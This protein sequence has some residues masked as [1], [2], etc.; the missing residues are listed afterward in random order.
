MTHVGAD[1]DPIEIREENIESLPELIRGYEILVTSEFP[2]S[3]ELLD[4]CRWIRGIVG[5]GPNADKIVD[6]TV[7]RRRALLS[8][9]VEAPITSAD[10]PIVLAEMDRRLRALD[11]IAEGW[12]GT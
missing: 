10:L 3:A 6:W 5:V 2:I 11:D 9:I 12:E 7:V 4:R 8:A 1:I